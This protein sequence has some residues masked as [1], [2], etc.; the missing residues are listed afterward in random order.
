MKIKAPSASPKVRRT[1]IAKI[2]P[3]RETS[4]TRDMLLMLFVRSS[5]AGYA[6]LVSFN[7]R[8][9]ARLKRTILR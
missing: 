5:V 7:V 8:L 4:G 2:A 1:M 9:C 3:E 6:S